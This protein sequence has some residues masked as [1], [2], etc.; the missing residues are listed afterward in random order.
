M[1]THTNKK[2]GLKI[3]V[4]Q[5]FGGE[6]GCALSVATT[7]E[8]AIDLLVERFDR[9]SALHF[10]VFL[11]REEAGE[12]LCNSEGWTPDDMDDDDPT[13]WMYI[14][15]RSGKDYTHAER[16]SAFREELQTLEPH[17]LP[18]KNFSFYNIPYGADS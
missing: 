13:K 16:V 2:G 11:K 10:E 17:I 3:Y 18:L 7:K 1:A 14:N 12:Y 15:G 8:R 6:T 5:K 4:W 9:E